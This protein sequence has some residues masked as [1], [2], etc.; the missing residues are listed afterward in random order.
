MQK[1]VATV[2][3]VESPANLRS[4]YRVVLTPAGQRLRAIVRGQTVAD[5]SRA[6]VMDETRLPSVFYFPR[7]DVRMD[8]LTGTDH[9]THCPFK[10]D[11]SYWTLN[12][13]GV[14][15]ENAAWSY[16]EPY[17]EATDVKAY[18]A[19]RWDAIDTWL[20][21]EQP[22]GEQPF[23]DAVAEANPFVEWLVQKAWRPKTLAD[24]V[25][26]LADVMVE[27]GLP[28][29][30]LRL[31]IRTLNPQ[32]FGMAYTWQRGAGEIEEYQVPHDTLHSPEY[33]N[34][35]FALIIGGQGGVRRRLE[36]PDPRLDFPVLKDLIEEGATDYV[37]MPLRFSDGLTNIIAL[38]SDA[39]GGFTTQ[40]L[41]QLYEVLPSLGR[42][43]E[44]HAQRISSLTLL[45]TYLGTSAGE[46]VMGG[47]VKRGD[48]E[49]L[50]AVIW[51]SD[52]RNST[53]L[54]D[55]LSRSDYLAALNRYFDCVAGT[56]IEHGGEVLKFIGDAVLAIFPIDDRSG[57]SP[58]A[59]RQALI[60][61]RDAQQ[62]IDAVNRERETN[63]ELPLAF[64]TGLH[65]GNI[66]YGNVGTSR[67][68]DFTV[69][70]PAV[71]EAARIEELCKSLGEPVLASSAFAECVPGELRS[72]GRHGLR[73][74]RAQEEIF[75]VLPAAVASSGAELPT[76]KLRN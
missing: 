73:G 17:D 38:V 32:L 66:T 72:L 11:A 41:G 48:G 4:G 9:R 70:G 47:L 44:T 6:L 69:I 12:V 37:A 28:L 2:A 21:D 35:P 58:A 76:G 67:R 64:G 53:Q 29:W 39:P 22:I 31:V 57:S 54:A 55:T 65:R 34:S 26:Q 1:Q 19:F 16:E 49:E 3:S 75:A 61:V 36:G 74:V 50:N 27:N 59:C 14:S 56:V 13:D 42:Q 5:S 33:L 46:R 7:D 51:F 23:D 68:L 62:R 52:L 10:G 40:D 63:G 43:L 71:N 8:L 30:R 60:A 18:L 45:R 24:S 20:A 15:I 25:E